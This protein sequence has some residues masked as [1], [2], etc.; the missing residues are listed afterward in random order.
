M[1]SVP[2]EPSSSSR[3]V[4]NGVELTSTNTWLEHEHHAI[5]KYYA[6]ARRV[7][8]IGPS[9][10]KRLK[11]LSRELRDV[12]AMWIFGNKLLPQLILGEAEGVGRHIYAR[13]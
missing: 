5:W 9:T 8:Y 3:T 13:R 1:A 10:K 6:L 11:M 7:V 12:I 4:S 2:V